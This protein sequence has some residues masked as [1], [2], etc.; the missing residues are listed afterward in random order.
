MALSPAARTVAEALEELWRLHPGVRD[1][2]LTERGAVRPYVNIFVGQANIRDAGGLAAPV[3]EGC[4][5]LIVPNVA[6]G[7]PGQRG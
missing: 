5:I 7:C 4:E 6:G 3:S 2:V 1:R